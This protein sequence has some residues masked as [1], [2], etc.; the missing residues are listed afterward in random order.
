[1]K[2]LLLLLVLI[3]NVLPAG[4]AVETNGFLVFE[5]DRYAYAEGHHGGSEIKRKFKVPLTEEFFANFT[6]APKETI[7]GTGFCC[8]AGRR[9][10]NTNDASFGFTWWLNQT[11]DH[12]WYIH[13]WGEGTEKIKGV[14][15]SSGNP[16]VTQSLT[17]KQLEDLDMS[18]QQSYVNA[19]DGVNVQFSAKY[20]PTKDIEAEGPIFT[21]PV[22]KTDRTM[23]FKGDNSENDP[24]QFFCVFQ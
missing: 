14:M 2:K 5:L 8:G 7:D 11:A 20:V 3:A 12:R 15:V 16:G 17:I 18:Y 1:M 4:A 9:W 21:A 13:M 22:R 23:L 10:T 24:I 6:H 19:Y